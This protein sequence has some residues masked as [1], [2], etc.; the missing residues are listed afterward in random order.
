MIV[1]EEKFNRKTPNSWLCYAK[2]LKFSSKKA[3]AL[4]NGN[5]YHYAG[6]N[7]V[8]YTD[9]DG[10]E[11]NEVQE[12]IMNFLSSQAEKSESFKSFVKN[13]TT[14]D[15]KR[16]KERE[17]DDNDTTR[18]KFLGIPLAKFTTQSEKNYKT[19]NQS[20]NER[21]EDDLEADALTLPK[22]N[23]YQATLLS[24]STSYNKPL[25]ITSKKIIN[26]SI[27]SSGRGFLFHSFSQKDKDYTHSMGHGCQIMNDLDFTDFRTNLES[28]GF[29]NGDSLKL[30]IR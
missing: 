15:V 23:D 20:Q 11:Q 30:R 13:H 17:V 25:S 2:S 24:E 21:F 22:G 16:G 12:N 19:K 7:P 3:S 14:L 26:G 1:L 28:L 10:R 4:T 9:P 29:K 18:I 8:R 5:L 6:N 27:L